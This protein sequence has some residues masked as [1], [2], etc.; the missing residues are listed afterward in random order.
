MVEG[1]PGTASDLRPPPRALGRAHAHLLQGR[2]TAEPPKWNRDSG[3]GSVAFGGAIL[4]AAGFALIGE[5]EGAAT[6]AAQEGHREAVHALSQLHSY[7]WLTFNAAWAAV[8]LATG[9]GARRKRALLV[10]RNAR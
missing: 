6:N 3:H 1:Q 7:D 2:A 5:L 10:I 8:L 9:L 4:G